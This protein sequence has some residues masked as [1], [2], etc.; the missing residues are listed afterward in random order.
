MIVPASRPFSQTRN[1][2]LQDNEIA[3]MYIDEALASGDINA[4]KLAIKHLRE[5]RAAR[6]VPHFPK[7]Y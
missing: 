6:R 2:L 4:L 7:V 1:A 3:A 5:A